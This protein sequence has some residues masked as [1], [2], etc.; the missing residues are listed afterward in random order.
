MCL[1]IFSLHSVLCSIIL[2]RNVFML[3]PESVI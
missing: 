2:K 3:I 1:L